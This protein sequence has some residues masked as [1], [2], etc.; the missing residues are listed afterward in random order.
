[1]LLF[2]I[3]TNRVDLLEHL[4]LRCDCGDVSLMTSVHFYAYHSFQCDF[5]FALIN[6]QCED[7]RNNVFRHWTRCQ[8]SKSCLSPW[9]WPWIR[10]HVDDLVPML[11]FCGVPSFLPHSHVFFFFNWTTKPFYVSI[12]S[13]FCS[14]L[15]FVCFWALKWTVTTPAVLWLQYFQ[16]KF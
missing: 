13:R 3:Q 16:S 5:C 12:L 8:K 1:M 10:E 9:D 2:C 15:L 14:L 11:M 4:V 7:Q 6:S